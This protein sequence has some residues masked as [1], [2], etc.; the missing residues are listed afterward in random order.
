MPLHNRLK[1]MDIFNY[2]PESLKEASYIG[3]F[4]SIAFVILTTILLLN[5]LIS[6]VKP[7]VESDML[8]DHLKD[9]K[10]LT[11]NIEIVFPRYPCGLLSLDKMDILHS[12]IVDVTEN[13]KKYRIDHRQYII[14]PQKPLLNKNLTERIQILTK[15]AEANEGC[16][17]IGN[18][19]VKMVPGNFHISFHNYGT[20][21][22][23]LINNGKYVPDMS[24]MIRR[25]AFGDVDVNTQNKIIKDFGLETL[26]TLNN[27]KQIKLKET[28]GYLHGVVNELR[29]VP[30]RFEY[31]IDNVYD[32]YQYTA[33]SKAIRTRNV[34]V[35]FNFDIEN[36]FMHFKKIDRSF[37]HM[38]IQCM[39]IL[40]GF[41]TL[42]LVIKL[43]FE[44]GM[45]NII[46]KRQ[47]GKLE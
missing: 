18:F 16:H 43:F 29:I 47:I 19:T 38:C 15:Q 45:M 24:Y 34:A 36:F 3:L 13:L 46:F 41:Y 14:G 8:I 21:F 37:S 2:I 23:Y 27:S 11:V 7:G 4:F 42:M 25:L 31:S 1:Q 28:Y 44:E 10:D 39:A 35:Y 12:H 30:S 26:H 17:I 9:N 22:Q 5:E 40:G 20:E 33:T 6:F 32:L